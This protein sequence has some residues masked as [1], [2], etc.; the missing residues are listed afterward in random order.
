MK[1]FRKF[2]I[3]KYKSK[4][5]KRMGK[6]VWVVIIS[7][8]LAFALLMSFI[9][10]ELIVSSYPVA[11]YSGFILV[12]L[13]LAIFPLFIMPVIVIERNKKKEKSG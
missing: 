7:C 11:D 2:V 12:I 3:L 8:H 5:G 13:T 4:G 6:S 1:N 9:L 10:T